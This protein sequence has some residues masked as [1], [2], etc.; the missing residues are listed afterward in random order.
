MR[1]SLLYNYKIQKALFQNPQF[2]TL[3]PLK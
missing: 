3:R 1:L 2:I